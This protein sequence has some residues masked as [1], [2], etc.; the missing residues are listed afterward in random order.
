MKIYRWLG[1]CL[2]CLSFAACDSSIA[3]TTTALPTQAQATA[4]PTVP[5]ERGGRRVDFPDMIIVYQRASATTAHPQK[6]T[7]YPGGRIILPDSNERVITVEA[8]RPLFTLLDSLNFAELR[9]QYVP[10]TPCAACLVHT[11]TLFRGQTIRPIV[12]VREANDV[13]LPLR[14]A[15]DQ[16]THGTCRCWAS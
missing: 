12:I 15:I 16:I 13:P 14:Q 5:N 11:I 3:A 7:L 8:M 9:E 2:M 6:W 1:L 4:L 10:A